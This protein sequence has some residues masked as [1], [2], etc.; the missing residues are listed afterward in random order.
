MTVLAPPSRRSVTLAHSGTSRIAASIAL[1]TPANSSWSCTSSHTLIPGHALLAQLH[2]KKSTK[3]VWVACVYADSSRLIDFYKELVASLSTFISSLPDKSWS[4]CIA[5]GDWNMVEHPHDRAPQKAP[6]SIFRRC[7]H[8]FSDLKAL[9]CA[10]DAAGMR[11]YPCGIS[12]H[13]RAS[14][15]SARLDRIYFPRQSCTAGKPVTVPT[16][17][18]D[19]CLVWAPIHI[20]NPRVELAKPAPCLPDMT[21]LDKH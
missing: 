2:H 17:W 4:G 15:Y 20:T 12:F 3:T 16:L 11:P 19:H 1:L 14:D 21:T 8:I 13:H 10:Q 6:D 9:C 18:S 7:L 5:L